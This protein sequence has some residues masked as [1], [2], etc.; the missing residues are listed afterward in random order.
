MNPWKVALWFVIAIAGLDLLFG[1]TNMPVL[2]DFL[3]NILT[4]GIDAILI[5]AAV[6]LLIFL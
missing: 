6:L 3:G 5:G 1:N 4:Q 2:P